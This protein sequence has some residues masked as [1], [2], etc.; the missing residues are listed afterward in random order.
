MKKYLCILFSIIMLLLVVGCDNQQQPD[1]KKTDITVTNDNKVD[2]N[3]QSEKEISE[4]FDTDIS[5]IYISIMGNKNEV[6]IDKDILDLIEQS[7][8]VTEP[9]L[10]ETSKEIGEVSIVCKNTEEVQFGKLYV[11]INNKI[12][13]MCNSNKNKAVIEISKNEKYISNIA[14]NFSE[15]D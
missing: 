1:D 8:A 2:T 14:E 12:Y 4:Q 9:E 7:K 15:K 6:N 13:F 5:K 10:N 11:D 3:N